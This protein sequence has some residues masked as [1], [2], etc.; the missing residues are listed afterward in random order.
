MNRKERVGC[1]FKSSSKY[2]IGT[3]FGQSEFATMK[4]DLFGSA[5]RVKCG[6]RVSTLFLS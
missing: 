6:A 4:L 5:S 2:K 3:L 1:D